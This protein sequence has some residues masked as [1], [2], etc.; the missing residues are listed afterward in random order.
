MMDKRM[1]DMASGK[2]IRVQDFYQSIDSIKWQYEVDQ[3][4]IKILTE[5]NKKLRDEKYK[6]EELQRISEELKKCQFKMRYG[7]ELSADEEFRINEWKLLHGCRHRTRSGNTIYE[8]RDGK[9]Q[10]MFTPTSIGTIGEI[11][12][13]CG[14]K[15]CFREL[16]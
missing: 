12:C 3:N 4:K 11:M 8:G 5:Q 13:S 14:E 15:Y 1:Y 2:V 10:Y 16:E 7:F 6:D 9:F